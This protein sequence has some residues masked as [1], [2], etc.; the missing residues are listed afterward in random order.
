MI[1]HLTYI[2]ILSQNISKKS[3]WSLNEIQNDFNMSNIVLLLNS[4]YESRDT[5]H[6]ISSM[7]LTIKSKYFFFLKRQSQVLV[8]KSLQ[9]QTIVVLPF[10]AYN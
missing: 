5:T 8:N 1:L 4:I 7:A 10:I 3:L 2:L 9:K 6:L